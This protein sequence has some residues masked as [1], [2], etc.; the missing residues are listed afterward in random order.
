MRREQK[1]VI[2]RGAGKQMD[3]QQRPTFKIKLK[4]S[5]FGEAPLYL[6]FTPTLSTFLEKS[7]GESLTDSLHRTTVHD[8]ERGSQA[9]MA[10]HQCLERLLQGRQIN[11]GPDPDSL[12][13]IVGSTFRRQLVEKPQALL[14][15][16][17]WEFCWRCGSA[18]RDFLCAD[19]R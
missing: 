9:A 17:E 14:A 15:V 12:R 16:R 5:F 11:S 2:I 3:A 6:R 10:V 18:R 13:H 19:G 1:N 4:S 7:Y 8:R